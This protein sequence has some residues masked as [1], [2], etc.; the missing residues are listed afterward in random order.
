VPYLSVDA[1]SDQ[2]MTFAYIEANGPVAPK[3]TVRQPK[4]DQ[5]GNRKEKASQAWAGW[6]A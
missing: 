6:N 3:S 1:V 5:R 2:L 4:H